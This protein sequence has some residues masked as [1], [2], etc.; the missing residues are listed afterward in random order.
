MPERANGGG[1]RAILK[2]PLAAVPPRVSAGSAVRNY[3][4]FEGFARPSA[5]HRKAIESLDS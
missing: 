2:L 1:L 4:Y 3:T 5:L